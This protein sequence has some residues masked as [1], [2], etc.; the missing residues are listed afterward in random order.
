MKRLFSLLGALVLVGCVSSGFRYSEIKNTIPPVDEGEAR[1]YFYRSGG[2]RDYF[3][4]FNEDDYEKLAPGYFFY[5]DAQPGHFMVYFNKFEK[6]FVVKNKTLNQDIPSFTSVDV[7]FDLKPNETKYIEVK[8]G[9]LR[10]NRMRI[11]NQGEAVQ[12]M[13]NMK[14][15]SRELGE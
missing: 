15:T 11:K 13:Q 9:G 14:Y 2:G 1:I 6:R 10:K 8:G 3:I 7:S 5:I 4:T 12:K